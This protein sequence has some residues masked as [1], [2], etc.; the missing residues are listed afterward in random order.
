MPES[1]QL[2][3][4]VAIVLFLHVACGRSLLN[5]PYPARDIIIQAAMI[6]LVL[7]GMLWL[8]GGEG[9]AYA[10]CSPQLGVKVLPRLLHNF[11]HRTTLSSSQRLMKTHEYTFHHN[12]ASYQSHTPPNLNSSL[13]QNPT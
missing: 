1:E 2:L 11:V 3:E 5:A 12:K 13:K 10:T 8:G 6:W 7:V 9:Y 4:P